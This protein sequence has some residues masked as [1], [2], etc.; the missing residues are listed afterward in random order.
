MVFSKKLHP[1]FLIVFPFLIIVLSGCT[2]VGGQIGSSIDNKSE[3]FWNV[4][5][6]IIQDIPEGTHLE[7]SMTD[8]RII[9][10]TKLFFSITDK[11]LV[12]Q[13]MERV[14]SPL[15]E[16][17]QADFA[18]YESLSDIHYRLP[19]AEIGLITVKEKSGHGHTI[20]TITG[21]VIDISLVTIFALSLSSFRMGP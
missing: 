3:D 12:V 17:F 10:G 1:S 19:M 5:P 6:A 9:E 4:T 2:I 13:K 11:T 7:V 21:A 8:G 14:I 16:D 18:G 20:G 15:V